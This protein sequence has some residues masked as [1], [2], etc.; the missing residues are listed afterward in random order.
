M[1]K[2]KRSQPPQR[3]TDSIKEAKRPIIVPKM[4][5]LFLLRKQHSKWISHEEGYHK[6]IKFDGVL[7]IVMEPVYTQ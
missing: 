5:F 6:S 1:P 4:N 7:L 2:P 3:K